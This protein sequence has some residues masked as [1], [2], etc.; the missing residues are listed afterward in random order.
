MVD[1]SLLVIVFSACLGF[2]RN[3]ISMVL[4]ADTNMNMCFSGRREL[5]LA[6]CWGTSGMLLLLYSGIDEDQAES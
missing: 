6:R 5:D 1:E 3:G 4:R 2:G